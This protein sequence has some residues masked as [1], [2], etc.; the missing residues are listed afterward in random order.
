MKGKS[1]Y[2]VPLLLAGVTASA[3]VATTINQQQ[4]TVVQAAVKTPDT[5]NSVE[6]ATISLVGGFKDS[7]ALGSTVTMPNVTV[8]GLG[9]T[10][11][12]GAGEKPYDDH[13]VTYKIYRGDKEKPVKTLVA[14]TDTLEYKPTYTGAYNVEITATKDGAVTSVMKGLTI[15]VEKAE[16]VINLPVNSKY[17]I[18][19]KLPVS[20]SNGLT[21]PAPTVTLI[22]KNGD[23]KEA[24][25]LATNLKVKVITPSD[26]LDSDDLTYDANTNTY[27]MTSAQLATAGTYQVRYEYYGDNDT[28]LTK[29]ETNFQVVKD[30]KAPTSLYLKLSGSVPTTGNVNKEVSLPKVTVLE[31]ASSTDGIKAHVTVKVTKLKADG[32]VDGEPVEITD[33]ENYKWTPAAEGNYVVS[34]QADLNSVYGNVSSEVYS[35][36]TIIKISD[37]ANPTVMATYAYKVEDGEITAIDFDNDNFGILPNVTENEKYNGSYTLGDYTYKALEEG[38]KVEDLLKTRRVDVPSV[39]VRD[40]NGEAN[41]RLPAIYGT[42]NKTG[43]SNMTF[44]REIVG[45]EIS[46]ITVAADSNEWS[47]IITLKKVGNYEIRYTAQDEAGNKV[48]ATYTLVVKDKTDVENGETNLTLN[49]GVSS[50]TDKE[51]LKFSVPTA[52]DTYDGYVDVVTKYVVM[53]GTSTLSE[54]TGSDVTLNKTNSD[55]KYEINIADI[56]H[57]DK[58]PNATAIKVIATATADSYLLGSRDDFA[59]TTETVKEKVITIRNSSDDKASADVKIGAVPADA[60]TWNAALFAANKDILFDIT[61]DNDTS[62]V[63]AIDAAGYA[64]NGAVGTGTVIKSDGGAKLSPFNQGKSVL[65]LPEVTFTDADENLGIT[66][67]IQDKYGNIV[68]KEEYEDI[69]KEKSGNVWN[70]TITNAAFKLSASGIYTVTYRAKDT[71]GNITVKSFG[72]RVNDKTAPT[73]VIDDEDKY[74]VNIQV[75]E[76]FEVPLGRLIKDGKEE[77]GE[78]TWTVTYSDGAECEIYSTG[79]VPLTE[80]TFYITYTG[81]DTLDNTQIL[82]DNSLFYVNAEDTTDPVFNEDSS[83]IL[84]PTVDWEPDQTTKDMKIDIPR[85]E[86]TDPIKNEALTVVYS[87]TAPDGSKLTVKDYEGTA[88]DGKEDVRYFE[89]DAQGV[90]TITYTATDAAGNS[91]T[92]SME[93][94]V[95]DCEAPTI[96]WKDG[97]SVAEE[98]KLGDTW[99]LDLS[100]LSIADNVTE[101]DYLNNNVTIKLVKPDGTTQVSNIGNDKSYKWKFDETGDYTLTITVKDEAGM[102][103]PYKFKISVPK[104]TVESDKV[105]SVV[106][107]VLVVV[108]VVIL[109]GVVIY[110]V[111]SSRKK[112][113]VKRTPSKNKKK[114]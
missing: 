25:N 82:K 3:G 42:D 105:D 46:K 72:I 12:T 6:G 9:S 108:S 83:Y 103:N 110:F 59:T 79:F 65:N 50:I 68:T 114:D 57:P 30:L 1:K 47:E 37:K 13:T 48:R 88:A 109:A 106:G 15:V 91:K 92:K 28:L 39:V 2:I 62:A 93:I 101:A 16:A 85:I 40:S 5:I 97:Y 69:Q 17:V 76:M 24:D 56:V 86:A 26:I 80:G 67:T 113:G 94:S 100:K 77:E 45:N 107:T 55:G 4:Q 29:L 36:A 78:V 90:Y 66:V 104:D 43:L 44:T 98:V 84:P 64:L 31:T 20:N 111:V 11:D 99:T 71:A 19:A 54:I 34:Y 38:D 63:K 96:T 73:I 51:T 27:K 41:F 49:I 53:Q 7:Y 74:G 33:Y 60:S 14:G 75:G 21:I 58:Y 112:T 52:K 87:V 23:E 10:V 89:A 95:G 70:Y 35:P 18:P 81:I 22:E 32:T 102:S 8:N 61:D